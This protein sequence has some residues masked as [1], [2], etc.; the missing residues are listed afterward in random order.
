MGTFRIHHSVLIII[1]AKKRGNKS[2]QI[3]RLI[4]QQSLS[5]LPP[6]LEK[7]VGIDVIAAR[8]NGYRIAACQGLFDHLPL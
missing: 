8:D 5:V 4:G 1:R 6:P 2:W 7:L 3:I